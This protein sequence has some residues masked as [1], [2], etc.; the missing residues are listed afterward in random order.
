MRKCLFVLRRRSKSRGLQGQDIIMANADVFWETDILELLL[1]DKREIVMLSDVERVDSGDYFFNTDDESRI[2]DYGKTLTRENR[3]CEY[4]GIAKVD[5]SFVNAFRT[6][7][8]EMIEAGDVNKWWE[9][10]LYSFVGTKDVCSL[11]VD[12]RFWAEVDVID[13]YKRILDYLES[14]KKC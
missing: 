11:D 3:T 7:L 4:V 8:I 14:A 2:T 1:S 9:N 13:D 12:G 10:V 5:K 6:R